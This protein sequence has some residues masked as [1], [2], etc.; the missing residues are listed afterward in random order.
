MQAVDTAQLS[1][2]PGPALSLEIAD[3]VAFGAR[4]WRIDRIE[5]SGLV[6]HLHVRAE[7]TRPPAARAIDPPESDAAAVYPARPELKILK[8]PTRGGGI[9]RG[10]TLA[11]SAS[12]WLAPIP[13]RAGRSQLNLTERLVATEAAGI[14]TIVHDLNVAA[15]DTWDEVNVLTVKMPGESLASA[16]EPAIQAGLNHLLVEHGDGWELLAWR[17]AALIDVDCWQLRGLLRG[18]YDTPIG[19]VAAGACA[20]L[21]DHRLLQIDLEPAEQ[22]RVLYWQAGSGDVLPFT[23]VPSSQ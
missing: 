22:G 14:G 1:F 7:A 19:A 21:A 18:L 12:P 6:R 20:I 15:A 5:D 3:R 23:F 16:S 11:V 8:A 17:S 2:P 9:A 4:T 13:V 10:P